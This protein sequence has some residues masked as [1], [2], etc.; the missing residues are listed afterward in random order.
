MRA[1]FLARPTINAATESISSG[2][3]M[4]FAIVGCEARRKTLIASSLVEDPRLMSEKLGATG[5]ALC[6]DERASI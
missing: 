2:L 3:S 1:Y 6:G 5:F 4:M